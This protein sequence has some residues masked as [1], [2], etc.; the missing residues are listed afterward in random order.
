[1]NA[2]PLRKIQFKISFVFQAAFNDIIHDCLWAKLLLWWRDCKRRWNERFKTPET[3][4]IQKKR[5]RV[6]VSQIFFSTVHNQKKFYR[7]KDEP[8]KWAT[9]S[10]IMKIIITFHSYFECVWQKC[11]PTLVPSGGRK[12]DDTLAKSVACCWLSDKYSTHNF[13]VRS[14]KRILCIMNISPIFLMSHDSQHLYNFFAQ[15]AKVTAALSPSLI[16]LETQW[17]ASII[18][19]VCEKMCTWHQA[20]EIT[21]IRFN[22]IKARHFP[23]E[24]AVNQH[25]YR[26]HLQ[27]GIKPSEASDHNCSLQLQHN[28]DR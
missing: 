6:L 10:L 8:N 3:R 24:L 2:S 7:Q 19:T 1:M 11:F 12:E 27:L 22:N 9:D 4:T 17:L 18:L 13:K 26:S 20:A 21:V 16:H 15:A 28:A 14:L 25:L 5:W 23:G